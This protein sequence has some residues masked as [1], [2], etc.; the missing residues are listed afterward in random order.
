MNAKAKEVCAVMVP[1][2]QYPL[3]EETTCHS[4]NESHLFVEPKE[5]S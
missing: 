4:T 3:V 2:M 1:Q 5:F